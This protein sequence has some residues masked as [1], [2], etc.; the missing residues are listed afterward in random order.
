MKVECLEEKDLG[1]NAGS[2]SFL[3]LPNPS[4]VEQKTETFSSW[5]IVTDFVK[6]S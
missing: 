3:K 6:Q 5:R 2:E 4:K 1:I